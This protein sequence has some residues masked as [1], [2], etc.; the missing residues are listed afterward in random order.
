VTGRAAARARAPSSGLTW[1]GNSELPNDSLWMTWLLLM[2]VVSDGSCARGARGV[3]V[4]VGCPTAA[5]R[6]ARAVSGACGVR[7]AGAGRGAPALQLGGRAAAE[8][9]AGRPQACASAG[10]QTRGPEQP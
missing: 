10:P 8:W 6:A 3:R 9:E 4:G 2:P 5:A 7:R 1:P